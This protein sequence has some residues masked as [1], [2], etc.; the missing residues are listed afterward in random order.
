M[1][2]AHKHPLMGCEV[3]TKGIDGDEGKYHLILLAKDT[4][5]AN[6]L[7]RIS[8]EAQEHENYGGKF[9]QRPLFL[10]RC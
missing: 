10:M 5:G 3:Y 9:P 6:N 2:D 8:S 4:I 1:R 7:I